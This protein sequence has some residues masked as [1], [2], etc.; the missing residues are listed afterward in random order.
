M[1]KTAEK[2]EK[3]IGTLISYVAIANEEKL[4]KVELK[5][6]FVLTKEKKESPVDQAIRLVNQDRQ[7]DYGSPLTDFSR[8]SGMLASLGYCFKDHN[9]N[10]RE[11]NAT[12]IPIIQM[13]VKLSREVNK[14]KDDN[15]VDIIGY[16]KTLD[17]VYEEIKVKGEA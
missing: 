16:A 11:L 3:P 7:K 12:D 17:M 6:D 13:C 5:G 14:H 15:I 10:I 1:V 4:P 2:N 9:G 8:S